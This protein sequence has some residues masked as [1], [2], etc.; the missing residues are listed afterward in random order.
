MKYDE[1]EQ[2]V[3]RL[4]R[5]KLDNDA[6]IKSIPMDINAF[7]FENTYIDNT[8]KMLDLSMGAL[9]KDL[10]GDVEWFLYELSDNVKAY[11]MKDDPNIIINGQRYWVHNLETYL[12]YARIELFNNL[13]FE[14]EY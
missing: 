5:L 3:T 4:Y 14:E 12:E 6:Y 1:F 11:P 7:V 13:V 2:L 10:Y 9:F 8:L